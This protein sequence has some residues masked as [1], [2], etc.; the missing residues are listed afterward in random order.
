MRSL[1]ML[2]RSSYQTNEIK[3]YEKSCVPYIDCK[4]TC[5]VLTKLF[6]V[7]KSC[8]SLVTVNRIDMKWKTIEYALRKCKLWS[9]TVNYPHQHSV[10]STKQCSNMLCFFLYRSFQHEI[11][12][13]FHSYNK[14]RKYFY[15][16]LSNLI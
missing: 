3:L 7:L 14:L 4:Y 10:R 9:S 5:M 13:P 16:D 12:S 11:P 8:L 1:K 2:H 15:F 6:K